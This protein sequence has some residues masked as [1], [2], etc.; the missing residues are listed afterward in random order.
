MKKEK[1]VITGITENDIINWMESLRDDIRIFSK[2]HKGNRKIRIIMSMK[3][4]EYIKIKL[5]LIRFNF[6]YKTN[7]KIKSFK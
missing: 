7:I 5:Y 4:S 2:S 6:K 1:Y 3:K